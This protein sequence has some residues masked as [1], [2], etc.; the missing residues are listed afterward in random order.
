MRAGDIDIGSDD[1]RAYALLPAGPHPPNR[2]WPRRPRER[3]RRAW[4]QQPNAGRRTRRPGRPD[5]RR[6]ARDPFASRPPATAARSHRGRGAATRRTR[7]GRP[8]TCHDP[9]VG[10]H[11]Q[12]S[13]RP[14]RT[15]RGGTQ[16]R[17]QRR[18]LRRPRAAGCLR[19][20]RQRGARGAPRH[21]G[22]RAGVNQ[23]GVAAA[24]SD[25]VPS[26]PR[27]RSDSCR[28]RCPARRR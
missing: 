23:R 17:R 14:S 3:D 26:I 4:R 7:D 28:R 1:G 13:H 16:V 12:G 24:G 22:C 8:H 27:H 19:H 2:S 11:C 5:R 21:P 18:H 6:V 15:A 20:P 10:R 25:P 9:R